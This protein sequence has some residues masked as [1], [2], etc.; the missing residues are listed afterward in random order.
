VFFSH[1]TLAVAI[2]ADDA[3]VACQFYPAAGP[4]RDNSSSIASSYR[5]FNGSPDLF[6]FTMY[7]DH[8]RAQLC[9]VSYYFS[10]GN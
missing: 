3:D 5:E 1:L 9:G 10:N 4:T 8:V 7:M 6:D 2:V